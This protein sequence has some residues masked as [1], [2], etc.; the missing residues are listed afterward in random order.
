MLI[1]HQV[2]TFFRAL[3]A[4]GA[5]NNIQVGTNA[6]GRMRMSNFFKIFILSFKILNSEEHSTQHVVVPTYNFSAIELFQT[7]NIVI[8]VSQGISR[9]MQAKSNPGKIH[10]NCFCK[11]SNV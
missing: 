6:L 2:K 11:F 1:F 7:K 9:K 4:Y 3:Y 10:E 5:N 8:V